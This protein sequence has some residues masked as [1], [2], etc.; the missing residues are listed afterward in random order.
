MGHND[1]DQAKAGDRD[2]DGEGVIARLLRPELSWRR[3]EQRLQNEILSQ[4]N[5]TTVIPN[6]VYSPGPSVAGWL[7]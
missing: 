6:A 7:G 5:A 1:L 4:M 3:W 2:L